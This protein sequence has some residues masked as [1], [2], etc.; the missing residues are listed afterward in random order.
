MDTPD[1]EVFPSFYLNTEIAPNG[2]PVFGRL[3]TE[4]IAWYFAITFSAQFNAYL[5]CFYEVWDPKNPSRDG[6]VQIRMAYLMRNHVEI[7]I[8]RLLKEA[9]QAIGGVDKI[10]DLAE[11]APPGQWSKT[12]AVL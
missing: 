9:L 6:L 10:V 5:V 1:Y 11:V 8:D 12:I 4:P 7:T 3:K 2:I